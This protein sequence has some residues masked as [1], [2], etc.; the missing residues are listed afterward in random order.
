MTESHDAGVAH[1]IILDLTHKITRTSTR[2]ST[3][4]EQSGYSLDPEPV[5]DPPWPGGDT[6]APAQLPGLPALAF[7][8]KRS[9]NDGSPA[10][11]AAH[12]QTAILLY[13]DYFTP[14]HV[15]IGCRGLGAERSLRGTGPLVPAGKEERGISFLFNPPLAR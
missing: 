14:F 1:A 7:Q 11:Q 12:L 2:G 4:Q 15:K 13:V 5:P 3:I 9:Q 10:F 8:A 6:E